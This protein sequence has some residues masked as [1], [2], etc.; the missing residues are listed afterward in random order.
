MKEP[1]DRKARAASIK[2][3]NEHVKLGG[4]IDTWNKLNEIA[5]ADLRKLA[6]DVLNKKSPEMTKPSQGY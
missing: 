3:F 4:T 6:D 2:A 5:A 1:K